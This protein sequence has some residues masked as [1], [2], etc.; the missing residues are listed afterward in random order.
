MYILILKIIYK[1]YFLSL[2]MTI[3]N[4]YICRERGREME[5]NKVIARI[6]LSKVF[7]FN[8]SL[9]LLFFKYKF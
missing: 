2:L 7:S 5:M 8:N 1:I 3:K 9:H 4:H 6:I